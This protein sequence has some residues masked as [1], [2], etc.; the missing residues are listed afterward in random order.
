M[1]FIPLREGFTGSE[2]FH[3]LKSGRLKIATASV[4]CVAD[5]IISLAAASQKRV[6]S[7]SLLF[8]SQL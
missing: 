8:F 7:V 4:S 2:V 6:F 3:V 5:P 1:S